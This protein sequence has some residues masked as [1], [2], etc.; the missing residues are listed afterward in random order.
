[1]SETTS[2]SRK[3]T[4]IERD[5]LRSALHAYIVQS[6]KFIK[7]K[8]YAKLHAKARKIANDELEAAKKLFKEVM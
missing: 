3:H 4:E 7:S 6:E 1:M 8:E 5:V 2:Q